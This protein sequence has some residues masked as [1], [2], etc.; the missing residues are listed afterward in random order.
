MLPKDIYPSQEDLKGNEKTLRFYTGLSNF[1]VLMALFRLVSVAV[2]EGRAAKLS[3]FNCF[4]LTLMKLRLNASNYDLGFRFGVSESTICRAFTKWIEAMDIRLSFLIMWP[5]R[6]SIQK[7]AILFST[8]L[9]S[10]SNIY[11]RLL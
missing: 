9:W 10:Q 7:H 11:H 2:P 5:D 8:S 1:T 6:E 4:I 3:H